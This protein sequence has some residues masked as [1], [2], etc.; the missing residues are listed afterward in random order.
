M[1][2]RWSVEERSLSINLQEVWAIRLG[3]HYFHHTEG[4]DC[5]VFTNNITAL[6]Y[7]EKPGDVFLGAQPGGATPPSM[8]GIF[9]SA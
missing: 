9:R 7:V 1:L 6:S 5:G 4:T 8:G 3:L 2:D